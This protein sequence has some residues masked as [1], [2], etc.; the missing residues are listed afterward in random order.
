MREHIKSFIQQCTTCQ[1]AKTPTTLPAGL[2]SPLPIPTQVW[3]D[4]AM[5]FITGLPASHGF[6]VIMV[7]V[8]RLTKFGHF[9]S[10]QI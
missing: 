3:A 7:V 2:L 1:Q 5:D 10:S 6:T 8:D 4:I 9:F